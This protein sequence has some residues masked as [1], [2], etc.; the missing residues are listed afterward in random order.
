MLL[1]KTNIELEG[2]AIDELLQGGVLTNMSSGS[3]VR[4]LI[5]V[6]SSRC[7]RVMDA[8]DTNM[9]MG[10]ITSASG[11]FLD[12]LGAGL[13][14]DRVDAAACAVTKEDKNIRFYVS[15]GVL[16]D[17][18]PAL[19]IPSGTIVQ[20]ASGDIQYTVTTDIAFADG[21]TEV[22]V[23]A[24]AN[25]SGEAYRVGRGMLTSHDLGDAN[26]LVTNEKSITNGGDVETDANYRYRLLNS[27][28]A[29]VTGNEIALR[30][31]ALST[32]GVADVTIQRHFNGP[33]TADLLII[34]TG[35]RLSDAVIRAARA[36]V[37]SVAAAGDFINVRGPRYVS[38]TIDTRIDFVR[39]V[40]D[41][42]KAD[43]RTAVR[44]AQL[45]YIDD[46]PIGGALIIQELRA[47]TQEAS[48]KIL[49]HEI[50]CLGINGRAQIL[51]NYRLFEDELFLPDE[52][53]DTPIKVI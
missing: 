29:L 13:G 24:V 1:K 28:A 41:S 36:R 25:G 52:S 50:L 8:I 44:A 6:L 21:V 16:S 47:R 12:L 45:D 37:S 40:P 11:Y 49:D 51:K 26:V 7:G 48:D 5:S 33:G 14:V 10:Y 42:E 32:P 17:Y 53:V 19:T 30:F 38:I 18:I 43:V 22:Y 34:P 20:D 35:N 3:R 2:E 39:S 4:A 27:R 9:A 31:A 15:S 23:P 46:I